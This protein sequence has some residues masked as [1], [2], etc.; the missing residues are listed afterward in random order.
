MT[1]FFAPP[2]GRKFIYFHPVL[3]AFEMQLLILATRV[4]WH[5][6]GPQHP[7]RKTL[8]EKNRKRTRSSPTMIL[9]NGW[10]IGLKYAKFCENLKLG[11]VG[12]RGGVPQNYGYLSDFEQNFAYL[13]KI[14]L[15][16]TVLGYFRDPQVQILRILSE[17]GS[18]RHPF[19]YLGSLRARFAYLMCI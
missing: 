19:G 18:Y 12:G 11:W 8:K 5:K 7:L 6:L 1:P 10:T 13:R 9:R 3:F 17:C 16:Q 4:E 2:F 15:W 14:W